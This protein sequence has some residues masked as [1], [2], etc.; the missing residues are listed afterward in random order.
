[1]RQILLVPHPILRQKAKDIK[2]IK[3]EDISI[4]KVMIKIMNNAPGVGLAA[5]QIGV[6]KKIVTVNIKDEKKDIKK[7]YILFNPKIVSYSK[8]TNIMEE[9]CLS[10]PEQFAE[11]ERPEEIIVEYINEKKEI[12]KKKVSGIESRVLQHEIDHLSGKLFIDYLSSLKRNIMIRKVKKLVKVR[13][14]NE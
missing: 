2:E 8:K 5:N 11:I 13:K 7:Q 1:M 4:A 3:E 12:V 9:G 10:I 6:L 14:T